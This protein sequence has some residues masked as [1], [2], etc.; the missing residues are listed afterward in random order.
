MF[1]LLSTDGVLVA[2]YMM[3]SHAEAQVITVPPQKLP[4]G[5]VRKSLAANVQGLLN[6]HTFY[7]D[8]NFLIKSCYFHKYTFGTNDIFS[9]HCTLSDVFYPTIYDSY[10]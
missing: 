4:S 3:Y 6:A 7:L 10:S 8:S 9:V 1:M 5:P 2:Y